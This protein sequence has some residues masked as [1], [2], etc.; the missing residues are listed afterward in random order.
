M[1]VQKYKGHTIELYDSIDEM[2]I[3]RFH[4]Y[5]KYL[6]IDGGV[7]S[8]LDDVINH[9]DRAAIYVKA[10]PAMALNE[11][12]NLKQAVYLM[13]EEI[14]PRCM[15]FA[16]LVAR[17]DGEEQNDLTDVGLKRVLERLNEA[18]KSWIDGILDSV[19]KKMDS[20]LSLYFPGKF[21]DVTSKEYIDS[22]KEHTL[23]T[24]EG[25]TTGED[26]QEELENIETRLALLAKPKVFYG[27]K[28]IEI[29][30]DKEFEEMC[31]ILSQ[32]IQT[33][34]HGMSVLQFYNA[35]DYLKKQT[36]RKK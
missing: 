12:Q 34:P 18:K 6:L 32:N 27:R 11:L 9:I 20:E 15:A 22:L 26:K 25:I 13:S 33:D 30:Y 4:K 14:S 21:E 5:N 16:V 29:S 31:I 36:K 10:N 7:G 2:P 28:S 3:T 17:I 19:K 1:N 24:L 8:D 23:L 35:F